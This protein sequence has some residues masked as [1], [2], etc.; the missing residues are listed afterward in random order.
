MS[1]CTYYEKVI[2]LPEA[3]NIDATFLLV[4]K[5][6]PRVIQIQMIPLKTYFNYLSTGSA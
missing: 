2:W 3:A 1:S 6:K 4:L 5:S